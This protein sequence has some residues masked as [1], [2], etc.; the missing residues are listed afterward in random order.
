M[1]K[2]AQP[3]HPVQ[4]PVAA[5]W[6]PY[7][8]DDRE[9]P[10]GELRS[11]LEAARWAASAFN[12]QPWQYIVAR[13][14]DGAAYDQVLSCLVDANQA[15][16][17]AAPVLMLTVVSENFARNGKP[18]G[19]A[20][21]DVGQASANLSLEATARGISVHQMAGIL[22]D[23]ARELFGIPEGFRAAT[24]VAIG[25]AADPRDLPEELRKRDTTPRTR[26]PLADF[27]FTGSWGKAAAL[28]DD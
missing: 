9:V 21:H 2:R 6:S 13:K 28:L 25:Y 27:V 10:A 5:R 17:Q 16:A 23:R 3:D 26:K 1:S 12:E 22:P 15:W 4:E 8:Y 14:S 20:M 11:L 24:G 19:S 7:G 18:N